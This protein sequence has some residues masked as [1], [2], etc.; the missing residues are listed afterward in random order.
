MTRL[1]IAVGFMLYAALLIHES[2]GMVELHFH[3]F[4][5]LAFLLVYRDWRVPVVAAA[6]IVDPPPRC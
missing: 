4:A 3:I 2:N 5:A 1:A 6:V